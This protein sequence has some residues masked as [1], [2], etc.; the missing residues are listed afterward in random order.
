MSQTK[1]TIY[2]I[3]ERTDNGTFW[4]VLD[5]DGDWHG[6]FAT[7]E[8]ACAVAWAAT[9][10]SRNALMNYRDLLLRVREAVEEALFEIDPIS[11][12]LPSGTALRR[13]QA[14][15]AALGRLR[16]RRFMAGARPLSAFRAR[17]GKERHR[18]RN[19]APVSVTLRRRATGDLSLSPVPGRGGLGARTLDGRLSGRLRLAWQR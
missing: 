6:D 8:M 18:E 14:A 7:R 2:T 11:C 16:R 13:L 4:R 1:Q 10:P 3:E 17:P 5:S 9:L 19:R 12:E 15:L